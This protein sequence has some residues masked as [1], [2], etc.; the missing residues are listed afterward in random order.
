M[1]QMIQ[2]ESTNYLVEVGVPIIVA[3]ITL[4]GVVWAASRGKK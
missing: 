1:Q 4:A 2:P 3:C